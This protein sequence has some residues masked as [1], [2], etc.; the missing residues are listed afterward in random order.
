MS[1]DPFADVTRIDWNNTTDTTASCPYDR[2]ATTTYVSY[3]FINC[4]Y[5][6]TDEYIKKVKELIRKAIIQKMKSEW[7]EFKKEFKPV[8]K[9]RPSAQLRG[10][11]FS[12]RGW[13]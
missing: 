11:C 8:P 5:T 13:A 7:T 1:G 6:Q 3:T 4:S 12:G 10:V 9:L 2:T